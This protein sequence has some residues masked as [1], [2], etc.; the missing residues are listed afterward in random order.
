M[1]RIFNEHGEHDASGLHFGSMRRLREAIIEAKLASGNS[2]ADGL[3]DAIERD[4][5]TSGEARTSPERP[6]EIR[7]GKNNAKVYVW[8]G[9]S[10]AEE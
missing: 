5:C 10:G 2:T 1:K 6:I 4:F 8:R 9:G 3:I 7:E